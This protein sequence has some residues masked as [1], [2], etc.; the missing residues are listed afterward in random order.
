MYNFEN[1]SALYE[2][3]TCVT[4]PDGC[5]STF[6]K[7][8]HIEAKREKSGYTF[9]F[10]GCSQ[11]VVD[12]KEPEDWN[13][14]TLD[15]S[16]AFY[17]YSL[18]VAENGK[19]IGVKDYQKIIEHWN[20]RRDELYEKYDYN[21]HVMD[22]SHIFMQVLESERMFLSVLKRNIFYRLL[23]WQDNL[24]SQEIEIRDFPSPRMITI[25]SF[26][27]GVKGKNCLCY[28]TDKVFDE[29][30]CRNQAGDCTIKVHRDA[31]GLPKEITVIANVV[32]KYTGSFSKKITLK[33]L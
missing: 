2:F 33:R 5:E 29:G 11:E 9:S 12:G 21:I 30:S 13:A 17:P 6:R 24:P 4:S 32:K 18:E 3:C 16:K 28:K 14:I 22:H 7:V 8:E 27:G 23:F 15:F 25:F 26:E 10:E 31:D 19:L 1:I 20:R